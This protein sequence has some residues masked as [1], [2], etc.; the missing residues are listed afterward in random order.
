MKTKNRVKICLCCLGRNIS[1]TKECRSCGQS[2]K[3]S[4]LANFKY[5]FKKV[6]YVSL[7]P[8]KAD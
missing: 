6:Y 3:K 8:D 2:F 5:F 1:N 4:F 7:Y